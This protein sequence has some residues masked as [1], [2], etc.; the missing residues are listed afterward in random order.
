MTRIPLYRFS[1]SNHVASWTVTWFVLDAPRAYYFS[2]IFH[3]RNFLSLYLNTPFIMFQDF[4][5]LLIPILCLFRTQVQGI[6]W[7]Q[8]TKYFGGQYFEHRARFSALLF[9]EILS[10]QVYIKNWCKHLSENYY[11]PLFRLEI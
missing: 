4:S 1:S 8:P 6:F 9:T 11:F 10:D 2:G 5:P 7:I 3:T